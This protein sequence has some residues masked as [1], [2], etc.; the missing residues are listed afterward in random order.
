MPF[1]IAPHEVL[2][3]YAFPVDDNVDIIYEGRGATQERLE[4]NPDWS[5]EKKA[6]MVRAHVLRR[7]HYPNQ[8]DAQC[9]QGDRAKRTDTSLATVFLTLRVR[10]ER[11]RALLQ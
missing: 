1:E 6:A 10:I 7:V 9:T 4:L 8:C 3:T 11:L 2:C 5:I